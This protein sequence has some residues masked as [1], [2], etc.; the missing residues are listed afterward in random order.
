MYSCVYINEQINVISWFTSFWG[1]LIRSDLLNQFPVD[2][3]VGVC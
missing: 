2:L 1:P 3:G